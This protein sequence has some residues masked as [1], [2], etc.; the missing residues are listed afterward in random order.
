MDEVGA[1]GARYQGT[2]KRLLLLLAV[3][4]AFLAGCSGGNSTPTAGATTTAATAPAD[5]GPAT[6]PPAGQEAAPSVSVAHPKPTKSG[7][8]GTD[9][10]R[11]HSKDLTLKIAGGDAAAGTYRENLVFTN[12]S[13]HKCTLYGYPGVSWV[14]GDNGKQVNDPFSRETGSK[15]TITLTPGGVAHSIVQ[16]HSTGAYAPANCKPVAVRGFRVYPPDETA[17]IFVS[18]P[19]DVCSVTGVN[20]GQIFVIEAGAGGN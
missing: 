4:A 2:M 8:A 6:T 11:C 7:T 19:Q 12:K 16:Q 13:G 15:Q 14:T 5:A 17:S 3:P 1:A 10:A 18:Q 20:L 9:V